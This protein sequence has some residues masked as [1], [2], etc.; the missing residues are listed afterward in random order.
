MP[1]AVNRELVIKCTLALSGANRIEIAA[2]G[3]DEVAATSET[4]TRA[5]ALADLRLDV[6]D[7]EGPVP[8]GQEATYELRIR[9]RGT[10]AAEGVEVF[11]FFSSGIEPIGGEG[12][13][14]RVSPGQVVFAPLPVL[15]PATEVTLRVRARATSAGNHIFRAEIHCRESGTRL[16]REETTPTSTKRALPTLS[17]S[18]PC[19]APNAQAVQNPGTSRTASNGG[20][21]QPR[22]P[23]PHP[24]GRI[25]RDTS[26]QS[27]RPI[28]GTPGH[29]AC[30]ATSLAAAK[31]QSANR[32]NRRNAVLGF[33]AGINAKPQAAAKVALA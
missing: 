24:V 2:I 20:G 12:H 23:R 22:K 18:R 30:S 32:S 9:N 27:R 21:Q 1:P 14:H 19:H 15:P 5:E 17:P 25:A 33:G 11:A 13:P 31:C 4:T 3:E 29:A 28:N 7:P 16:V 6:K 26:N 8:V 10:K